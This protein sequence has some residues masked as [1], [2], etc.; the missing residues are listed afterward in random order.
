MGAEKTGRDV[1]PE[2][3]TNALLGFL[4][5]LL[6]V[7]LLA[8]ATRFLYPRVESGRTEDSGILISDVIQVEVLNGCG[9]SGVANKFTNSLR[10]NGFDVVETGNFDS[11]DVSKSFVIDRTG[12][13]ENAVRVA[14]ALGI[15]EKQVIQEV[16][17]QF[18]LDATVV[19]G[20]DYPTLKLSDK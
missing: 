1:N 12:N 2:F 16:S 5:V 9:V 19:I 14:V 11:K 10:K 8:L 13:L 6:A 18:F 3:V 17:K 7:L 4:G 15:D 20:A